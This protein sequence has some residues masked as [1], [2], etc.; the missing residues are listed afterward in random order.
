M[1]NPGV[2]KLA[3]LAD[4]VED[5]PYRFEIEDNI[6]EAIHIHYRDFRLDLTIKEFVALAGSMEQVIEALVPVAGFSCNQFDKV[7][8]VGLARMLPDLVRIEEDRIALKELLVE[9]ADETGQSVCCG[10]ERSRIVAALRGNTHENDRREQVNYYNAHDV[11]CQT[12]A[13]R[14]AYNLQKIKTQGYP[15]SEERIL[16]FNHSNLIRDGGH[17]AGILYMLYGGD[18]QV[19]VRRLFF[20]GGMYSEAEQSKQESLRLAGEPSFTVKGNEIEIDIHSLLKD[21][22]YSGV[23]AV[24]EREV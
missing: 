7:N 17:R 12:N 1:S 15:D 22:G 6:G 14:L 10:L 4:T 9:S 8:L 3:S 19:P 11:R 5:F 24:V 2:I 13:E 20:R 21:T 16:L 18:Y 23:A